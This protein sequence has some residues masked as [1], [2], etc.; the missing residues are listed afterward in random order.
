MIKK[1]LTAD[2]NSEENMQSKMELM[3]EI[4]RGRT[5][6]LE[7][8]LKERKKIEE[9][10]HNSLVELENSKT[11]ALN[12][13]EDLNRETDE[14]MKL[15]KHLH[16]AEKMEALGLL[17]GGVAHDLNNILGALSIY[18]E[19]LQNKIPEGNPL[20]AYVNNILSSCKMGEEIIH[21]LMIFSG[22]VVQE[23]S[24]VNL[25]KV[26]Y[27][28]FDT[29]VFQKLRD[30][31]PD[32]T[33]KKEL[34]PELMNIKGSLVHLEKTVMNLILNAAEAVS[35]KGEVVITTENRFLETPLQS[36]VEIMEGEYAVLTVSD[37]GIGIP[38]NDIN[39]IFEPFY[40]K[41]VMG[42]KR[43]TG[44]GLTIV[45]GTVKDHNGYIDLCSETGKGSSFTLYFPVTE[46]KPAENNTKIPVE[47]YLGDGELIL[48]VD[49]MA[50]QRDV[51]DRMLKMLGYMVHAVSSG[52]E[53]VEYL[54][55]HKPDLI[56]LDMIMEPGIDGLETY[57][58]ILEINPKQKAII[59][60]GFSATDNVKKAQDL[61]AGSYIKKPY[62][63]EKIGI[64]IRDELKR[65]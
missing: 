59:V 27:D 45:W 31:N 24:I 4:I 53:A 58:R 12:L 49:D 56:L 9:D 29:P 63:I 47:N 43:G 25:N 46:D 41:K 17:A 22:S 39:K 33:F 10:L 23:Y 55:T 61:G 7:N 20:K 54:K 51:A 30:L 50:E 60:S 52:E 5:I 38:V 26:I 14:R 44:L 34:S 15:E 57:R 42:R 16:R 40:T 35:G 28:F 18:T 11:A 62:L 21:D 64:A 48:V 37:T 2:K 32:I 1:I 8:E 65:T 36:Y 6:R 13:L 19:L 3:D